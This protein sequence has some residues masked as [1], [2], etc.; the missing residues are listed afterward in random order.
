[1]CKTECRTYGDAQTE[2]NCY[3]L[4]AGLTN[5]ANVPHSLAHHRLEKPIADGPTHVNVLQ[6]RSEMSPE[7][8]DTNSRSR[9]ECVAP[10]VGRGTVGETTGGLM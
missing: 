1:V 6:N 8:E 2:P 4:V 10:S 3:K 9:P 5:A 7:N